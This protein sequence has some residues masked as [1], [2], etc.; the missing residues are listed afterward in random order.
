LALIQGLAGEAS[1]K[2]VIGGPPDFDHVVCWVAA[3]LEIGDV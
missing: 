2:E 3:C 1:E